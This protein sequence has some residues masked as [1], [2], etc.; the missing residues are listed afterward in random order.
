MPEPRVEP[1]FQNLERSLT[2]PLRYR[3]AR[4]LIHQPEK[5]FTGR[6]IA[7]LLQVSH[8]GVQKAIR[9]IVEAGLAQEKR[10]GRS[11]VYSANKD[12]YLFRTF[13]SW[14]GSEGRMQQEFVET[15]RSK[16]EGA[17]VSAVVFGSF[18][19][20]SASPT[21]DLDLLIV[22]EDRAEI[23]KRLTT[24]AGAFARRYGIRISPRV[25]TKTELREKASLLYVKAA[26]TEGVLVAGQ[27]L[28]KVL[29]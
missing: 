11:N 29:D 19:K 4:L 23:E 9:S 16:L 21:S 27:P 6:E 3:I 14:F 8:T 20:G 2:S 15:L 24:L 17:V 13:R 5:E 18:A 10:I 26:R 28:E 1:L 7:R 12:S 25:M 22:A